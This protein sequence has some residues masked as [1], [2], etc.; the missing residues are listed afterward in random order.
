MGLPDRPKKLRRGQVNVLLALVMCALVAC[1]A[2]TA[3][4]T[5]PE[6]YRGA[7]PPATDFMS[8]RANIEAGR[9][10]YQR[11][12]AACHGQ[13]GR[14]DGVAGHTQSLKPANLAGPKGVAQ[15]PLDYWFW[16]VSEGGAVEPFH[17][18]GSVMPAWKYHLSAEE[19]WQVIAYA[20]SLA[21]N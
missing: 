7:T 13:T 5:V 6:P 20:R 9:A 16:R 4:V 8:N 3:K 11:H 10:I 1:R 15:K 14:G 2:T 17:S 12:C 21:K 18:Q 19:R